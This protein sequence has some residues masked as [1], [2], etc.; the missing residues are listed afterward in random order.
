MHPMLA[1]LLHLLELERIEDNIFRGESRDIGSPRVFG[2][3][4]LGQALSAA[5]YT[6]EGREVHSLHAYFLRPGD[7]AAHIVYEVD[8]ARDGRSFSNRRVVAI[9][10]G[11]P[12]FNMTASFQTPELGL[13]HQAEMPNVPPPEKLGATR[14]IDAQTLERIPEKMRRSRTCGPPAGRSRSRY[15]S[16]NAWTPSG[17]YGS[18]RSTRCPT[19]PICTAICSRI[20]PITSSSRP[21]RCRTASASRRA[22]CSSRAWFL[23][24]GLPWRASSARGAC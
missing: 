7:T 23:Q 11:Q 15:R 18:R 14:E 1:D 4:V 12:I 3:Q 2:G 22:K 13:D 9:Q 16:R 17:T 24:C 8:R 19:V 6:V 10:H 21:R 20:C 5:S